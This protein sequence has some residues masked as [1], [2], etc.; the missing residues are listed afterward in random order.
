MTRIF[1][2]QHFKKDILLF[3]DWLALRSQNQKWL[4]ELIAEKTVGIKKLELYPNLMYGK[5]LALNDLNRGAEAREAMADALLKFPECAL[6]IYTALVRKK[7][8]V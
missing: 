6:S 1:L 2:T 7:E 4:L 5:A 3:V 8:G